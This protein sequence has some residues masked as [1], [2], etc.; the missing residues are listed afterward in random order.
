MIHIIPTACRRTRAWIAACHAI[1]LS[2]RVGEV[3]RRYVG[4]EG[5]AGHLGESHVN[6]LFMRNDEYA[7]ALRLIALAK[8]WPRRGV[9][10]NGKNKESQYRLGDYGWTFVSEDGE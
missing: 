2:V 1:Y 7:E 10:A 4:L 9:I 6:S 3:L 8:R 5:D